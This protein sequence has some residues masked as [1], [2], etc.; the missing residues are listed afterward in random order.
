[1]LGSRL[2]IAVFVEQTMPEFNLRYAPHLGYLSPVPQFVQSVGNSDPYDHARFAH[3]QGFAGLFHP[4]AGSAAPEQLEQFRKGLDEFQLGAGALAYAPF[5]EALKPLWVSNDRSE[6][7]TSE[8]QSL[9]RISYAVFCIKKKKKMG[10]PS[11]L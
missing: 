8:L 7:H 2:P 3:D 6:E 9:M 5:E 10:A 11:Q 4:W 1:M